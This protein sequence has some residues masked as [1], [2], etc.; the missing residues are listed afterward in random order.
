M[1]KSQRLFLVLSLCLL[2][3]LFLLAQDYQVLL[4]EAEQHFKW[5]RVQASLETCDQ[6]IEEEA[7]NY[8]AYQK[9]GRAYRFLGDPNRALQDYNTALRINPNHA[10]S[11]VGRAQTHLKIS[12]YTEAI[13]DYNLALRI[14]PQHPQAIQ[15]LYNRALAKQ[16]LADFKAALVDYNLLLE[17][18]PD[19]TKALV[20]RGYLLY[21]KNEV[22]A[23]CVD[24]LKA[25]ELGN[26]KASKNAERACQCCM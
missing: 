3:S 12:A 1:N 10:N 4:N 16:K 26:S 17:A 24:W 20:N 7:N 9:R 11:Y 18:N 15:M 23:A 8:Q 13:Q 21:Q 2:S 25:R 6:A 14:D 5:G 22:R 19:Y